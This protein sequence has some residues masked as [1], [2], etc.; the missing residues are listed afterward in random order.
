M[1]VAPL[2]ASAAHL[3]AAH[4]VDVPKEEGDDERDEQREEREDVDGAARG[5]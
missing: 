3:V 2:R 4:V 5:A 1:S